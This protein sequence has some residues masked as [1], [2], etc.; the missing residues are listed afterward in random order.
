[1]NTLTVSIGDK[2]FMKRGTQV[3][4]VEVVPAEPAFRSIRSYGCRYQS[5]LGKW[6]IDY[7]MDHDLFE[8]E[9]DAIQAAL[10]DAE[11]DARALE[12][13]IKEVEKEKENAEYAAMCANLRKPGDKELYAHL[14]SQK[15]ESEEDEQDGAITKTACNCGPIAANH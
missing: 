9:L 5:A 6:H 10:E 8:N 3:I 15:W 12:R 4:A 7:P 1:M 2:L 13:R 14:A 11:S